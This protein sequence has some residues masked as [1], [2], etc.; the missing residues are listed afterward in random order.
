L[1]EDLPG[2][3]GFRSPPGLVVVAAEADM[4]IEHDFPR[5]HVDDGK[6]VAALNLDIPAFV[7]TTKGVFSRVEDAIT[8]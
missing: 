3:E 8:Q 7:W 4:A 5:F 1:F 2:K 6:V